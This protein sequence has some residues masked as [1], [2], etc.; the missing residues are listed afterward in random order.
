MEIKSAIAWIKTGKSLVIQ[1]QGQ[2]LRLREGSAKHTGVV[3]LINQKQKRSITNERIIKFLF[4]E[5]AVKTVAVK[6]SP[7]IKVKKSKATGDSGKRNAAI[8]KKM[9][10]KEVVLKADISW[11]DSGKS[12][13][14]HLKDR[15]P[16]VLKKG[17]KRC[18]QVMKFIAKKEKKAVIAEKIK[19]FLFPQ[20]AIPKY[21]LKNFTVNER[22]EVLAK[23]FKNPVHKSIAKRI[24]E[25]YREGLPY[26]PLLR[27]WK[28]LE[29]NPSKVSK[30]Q[31][32]LFLTANHMPI[33]PD[34]HFLAY[35]RVDNKNGKLVDNYTGRISNAIG[36]TVKM[37]RKSVNA[38]RNQTCSHGL[39]VAAWEYAQGYSGNT[40]IE[41]KVN[42]RDVVAVP[43]D[44]NNQKM[45]V[46]QYKVAC[47]GKSEHS[48]EMI[49]AEQLRLKGKKSST[50]FRTERNA[51]GA[52]KKISLE[53]LTAKEVIQLVSDETGEHINMNLKNK[54]GIVNKAQKI[55]GQYAFKSDKKKQSPGKTKSI[56]LNTAR[57]T[58][59]QIVDLVKDKVGKT[60]DLSLKNKQ[61]IVQK[62]TELLKEIGLRVRIK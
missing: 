48:D 40:L 34:G 52:G 41:I 39:H 58:A 38:D 4:G 25:F 57:Q 45:R 56:T 51:V 37:S 30:D 9:A 31:L 53:G 35:K 32:F 22:G 21:T 61:G 59:K 26:E 29:L 11:L 47:I 27:F 16:V 14:I 42:P 54:K 46:C 1:Y 62:A 15:R 28:N 2:T 3:R 12:L 60:I 19:G 50:Q 20:E 23:G 13:I 5:D 43:D 6:V 10:G 33:T 44:Y 18:D 36:K 55:L 24:I 17:S 8:I 7:K 49:P